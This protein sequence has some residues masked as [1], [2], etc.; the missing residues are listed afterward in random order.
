[1]SKKKKEDSGNNKTNKLL[2]DAIKLKIQKFKKEL[3]D[4]IKKIIKDNKLKIDEKEIKSIKANLIYPDYNPLNVNKDEYYYKNWAE[5]FKDRDVNLI[6]LFKNFNWFDIF[7]I[8]KFCSKLKFNNHK[9]TE[10]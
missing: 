7:D 2:K 5:Y 8:K 1:M 9:L 3:D 10:K 6:D 4:D